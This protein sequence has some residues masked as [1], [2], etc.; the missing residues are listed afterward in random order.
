PRGRAGKSADAGRSV[1]ALRSREVRC[2][3][4]PHVVR[5]QSAG[6][7]PDVAT[8]PRGSASG[9][10]SQRRKVRE[11]ATAGSDR[12]EPAAAYGAGRSRTRIPHPGSGP[13]QEPADECVYDVE[14]Q[15]RLALLETAR[16]QHHAACLGVQWVQEV[17]WVHWVLFSGFLHVQRFNTL[18][19]FRTSRPPLMTAIN[20]RPRVNDRRLRAPRSAQETKPGGGFTGAVRRAS[21]AASSL[22]R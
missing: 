17:Q 7:P 16:R 1:Q 14:G 4:R 10:R 8:H 2:D 22:T 5:L 6:P 15:A 18:E 9:H 3:D 13:L 21:K 20:P 19:E 11:A 12:R